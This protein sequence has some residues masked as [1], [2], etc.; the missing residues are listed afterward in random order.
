MFF[1]VQGVILASLVL[2]IRDRHLTLSPLSPE[3]SSGVLM[4]AM[5]GSSALVS[6]GAGRWI[7]RHG[8]KAALL[9]PASLSCVGGFALL[10]VSQHLGGALLALSAIGIG[11]GGINVP[12]IVIL[13][14]LVSADR[15]GRAIGMY[16]VL[17]DVGGSLGPITGL[18]AIT[19]FGSTVTLAVLAAALLVTVP[20]AARLQRL[21][22]DG[23]CAGTGL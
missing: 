17:G 12:L 19:R 20:L 1:A 10:A 18:E 22:R 13:G 23:A 15:Y 5:L 6:W 16:Q 3:G 7:D 2:I 14:D 8:R 21:E 9:L 11:T 4:A